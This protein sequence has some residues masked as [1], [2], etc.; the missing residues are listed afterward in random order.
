MTAEQFPGCEAG[1]PVEGLL[2]AA[3]GA[4]GRG[5]LAA[6]LLVEMSGER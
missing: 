4:G 5:G 6:R 2:A 3:A 1:C